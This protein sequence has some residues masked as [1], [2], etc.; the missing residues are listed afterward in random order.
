MPADTAAAVRALEACRKAMV[1]V[2]RTVKPMGNV[3]KAASAVISAIDGL[4]AILTGDREFFWDKGSTG[5]SGAPRR[6]ENHS[7]EG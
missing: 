2:L 3:Y 1:D 5:S 7:G 4:A 6:Q